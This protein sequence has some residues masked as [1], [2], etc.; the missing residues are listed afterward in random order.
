L[1]KGA[2]SWSNSAVKGSYEEPYQGANHYSYYEAYTPYLCTFDRSHAT[3]LY[4]EPYYDSDDCF[5]NTYQG[6]YY[7]IPFRSSYSTFCCSFLFTHH[8]TPLNSA[9]C[10][11][12]VHT[13]LSYAGTYTSYPCSFNHAYFCPYHWSPYLHT[14]C[15]DHCTYTSSV[16]QPY[17]CTF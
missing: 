14:Y 15:S 5:A 1:Y 6:A 4:I 2:Y 8:W 10:T 3:W 9:Y 12:H 16:N 13:N 7:K 11:P 17:A